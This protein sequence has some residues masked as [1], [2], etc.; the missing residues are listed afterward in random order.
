MGDEQDLLTDRST[1]SGRLL[2]LEEAWHAAGPDSLVLLDELGSGTDPE[3]GSALGVSLLAALVERRTLAVITTHLTPLAAAALE[4]D[5][6]GCAAMEF[7]AASGTPTF[8]LL[9]G[10]PGGSEA[11]ALARRLG[12]PAEWLDRAEA[13]LG[14]QHRDLQRLLAEVEALRGELAEAKRRSEQEADDAAK[15]RRRLAE[16]EKELVAERKALGKTLRGELDAFRRDTLERLRT[17]TARIRREMEEEGRRR[18]LEAAAVE[19]LFAAAPRIDDG[20]PEAG[21]ELVV[22]EPVRHRGLGWEGTLEKLDRGRAEVSVRGKTVRCAEDDLVPLAAPGGDRAPGGAGGRRGAGAASRPGVSVHLGGDGDGGGG[23]GDGGAPALA[24]ELHLLGKRV[25]P[26]LRELDDYLDRALLGSRRE[27]RVVHGHGTGA[28]R[29]A[30]REHLRRH[31]AVA[32]QRPGARNEGGDGA[33]VA[34]LR[35]A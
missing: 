15:L 25:E 23:G 28:L 8:H 7:S 35:D 11:L 2:R 5:G 31:P 18:G 17:E 4:M 27:V 6:A 26:A 30:V 22:G 34:T 9:P 12:L 13:R 1:F 14:S 24:A 19:R 10:P 3:E 32:S 20:E 29:D 21:G 16:E 33:T